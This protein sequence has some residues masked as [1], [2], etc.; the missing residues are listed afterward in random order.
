MKERFTIVPAVY[1]ILI[2]DGEVLLGRRRNTGFHDGEYML[3]SGHVDGGETFREAMI[4][5]AKEEI[6]I[7]LDSKDLRLVHTMHRKSGEQERGD[8]FFTTERWE[9]EP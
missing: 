4:R 2:R 6:G 8:F 7:V 3:P 5:E 9:G 1:L